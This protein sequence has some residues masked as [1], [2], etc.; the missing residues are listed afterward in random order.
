LN[1]WRLTNLLEILRL[2]AESYCKFTH[3][4]GQLG[5][6]LSFPNVSKDEMDGLVGVLVSHLDAIRTECEKLGLEATADCIGNTLATW[7]NYHDYKNLMHDCPRI[8]LC[9]ENE[10]KRRVCFILPRESQVLYETPAKKW[11]KTLAAFPEAKDDIEEMSRCL[12]FGRHAAAVFHALL[13]VEH[14]IIDLGKFIDVADPKTGWDA[15]YKKLKELLKLGHNGIPDKF[16]PY[17]AFLEAINASLESMKVAWRNK[18]SHAD[19]RLTVLTSDFSERVTEEIII[20]SRSFMR[21]LATEGP[22]KQI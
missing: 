18:I 21:L 13:V 19:K 4:L 8:S 15:T 9:L 20:A 22:R 16:K 11:Q 5:I 3:H 7:N 14:G 10:L 2:Y 6:T 12:A 17:F 1:L